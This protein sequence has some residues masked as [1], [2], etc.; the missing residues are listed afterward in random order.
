MS[1]I[2]RRSGGREPAEILH[3]PRNSRAVGNPWRGITLTILP[4][5]EFVFVRDL[6]LLSYPCKAKPVDENEPR[7]C[8]RL[9]PA[10]QLRCFFLS[11]I[12]GHNLPNPLRLQYLGDLHPHRDQFHPTQPHKF[13]SHSLEQ[14]LL[15]F[16]TKERG[17]S[18]EERGMGMERL[19]AL[20]RG[21]NEG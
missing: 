9:Y 3:P 4:N 11:R 19:H 21:R 20:G 7:S 2:L 13:P 5:K 17:A 16:P 15:A 6:V 8:Y 18:F 14:I 1:Q 12:S 10:L